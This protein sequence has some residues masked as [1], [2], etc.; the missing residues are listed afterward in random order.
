[1]EDICRT[2]LQDF[3]KSNSLVRVRRVFRFVQWILVAQC[4]LTVEELGYAL[5]VKANDIVSMCPTS[6]IITLYEQVVICSTT[7]R[8]RTVQFGHLRC[9]HTSPQQNPQ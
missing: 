8:V 4:K 9:G 5:K 2:A 1:M 6:L 3:V 7:A